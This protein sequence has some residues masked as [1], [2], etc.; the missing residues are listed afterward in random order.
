MAIIGYVSAK[1]QCCKCVVSRD[2]QARDA[3]TKNFVRLMARSSHDQ[4]FLLLCVSSYAP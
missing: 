3:Q 1:A 2:L 4:F